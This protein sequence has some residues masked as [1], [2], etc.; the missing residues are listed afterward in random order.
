MLPQIWSSRDIHILP[1]A[2]T[3][4]L[5][6]RYMIMHYYNCDWG[7]S[8]SCLFIQIVYLPYVQQQCLL[9][10][11]YIFSLNTC[12]LSP[13]ATIIRVLV[14]TEFH[15][16]DHIHFSDISPVTIGVFLYQDYIISLSQCS[17]IFHLTCPTIITMCSVTAPALN[18]L[19]LH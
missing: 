17:H 8:I 14:L 9:F 12:K 18:R 4:A 1:P 16:M 7:I 6:G 15:N 11:L 19:T 5:R 10:A 2:P 3:P 13:G